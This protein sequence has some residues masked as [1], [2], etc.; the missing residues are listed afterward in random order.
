MDKN[1]LFFIL[2]TFEKQG[3]ILLR[4]THFLLSPGFQ[5]SCKDDHIRSIFPLCTEPCVKMCWPQVTQL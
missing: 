5:C 2:L 3:V 4:T 1:K